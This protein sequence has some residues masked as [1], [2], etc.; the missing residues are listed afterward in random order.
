[1]IRTC[2]L[3]SSVS[4]MTALPP[5]VS[6]KRTSE[7]HP[8]VIPGCSITPRTTVT[9]PNLVLRRQNNLKGQRWVKWLYGPRKAIIGGRGWFDK[10]IPYTTFLAPKAH[11]ITGLLIPLLLWW[12]HFSVLKHLFRCVW[13]KG[14]LS[15]DHLHLL[16]W[17]LIT[18]YYRVVFNS[19]ILWKCMLRETMAGCRSIHGLHLRALTRQGREHVVSVPSVLNYIVYLRSSVAGD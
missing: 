1:M 15:G 3:E 18:S 2:R 9:S 14:H 11:V 6:H 17:L 8:S 4:L 19:I 16:N 12:L 10:G 13:Q 5:E 7:E